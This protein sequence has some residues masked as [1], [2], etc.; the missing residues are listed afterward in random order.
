VFLVVTSLCPSCWPFPNQ[1]FYSEN[2][3]FKQA[4]SSAATLT[5]LPPPP[6]FWH[7]DL[8]KKAYSHSPVLEP[9]IEGKNFPPLSPKDHDDDVEVIYRQLKEDFADKYTSVSAL[10]KTF[11]SNQNGDFW[12]DLDAASTRRLYKTLL[13][14]PNALLELHKTGLNSNG[15]NSTS[16]IAADDLAPLA[17]SARLAAK[18]YAR[19]RSRIPARIAANFYDGW[20]QLWK[21]GNFRMKG[22]TYRQ[23][24][25]KYYHQVVL[26]ELE[27]SSASS[28]LIKEND[29]ID[30][31][32][33]LE[34]VS[35]RI[36]IRILER[37]CETNEM[38]D[39]LCACLGD[40]Q[41]SNDE[42]MQMLQTITEQLEKDVEL[43]LNPTA[44]RRR[45][46][47][48]IKQQLY[49]FRTLKT[50]IRMKR[51]LAVLK[52]K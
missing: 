50:L 48:S 38:V 34:D 29:S 21:T 3:G 44:A 46:G 30:G 10:Q 25:E 40:D 2:V 14:V 26:E 35:E 51:T 28:P 45:D 7:F 32:L 15:K 23:I 9:E 47:S 43:L 1:V 49:L 39:E 5:H 20:R 52:M 12:G 42:A 4:A 6:P 27:S 18:L 13:L 36:S 11:G 19:N 31:L 22:V 37:S 33:S 17:Y 24:W 8:V 16:T 41:C